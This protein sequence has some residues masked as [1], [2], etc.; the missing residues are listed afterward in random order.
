V[1]KNK[2]FITQHT[3]RTAINKCDSV[4]FGSASCLI[5]SG[6]AEAKKTR[7]GASLLVTDST[8]SKMHHSPSEALK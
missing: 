1:N 7:L 5:R 3:K 6:S 2:Q 4:R 8:N